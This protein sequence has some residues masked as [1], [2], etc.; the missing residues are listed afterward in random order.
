MIEP[1]ILTEEIIRLGE[2]WSRECLLRIGTLGGGTDIMIGLAEVESPVD[3]A[4]LKVRLYLTTKGLSAAGITFLPK[5]KYRCDDKGYFEDNYVIILD[6]SRE[7]FSGDNKE[8]LM[9]ATLLHELTHVVDPDFVADCQKKK[10]DIKKYE[11]HLAQYT[12]SSEQRAFTSMWI[13]ELKAVL[14]GNAVS[15]MP[16]LIFA[17]QISAKCEQ[18]KVFYEKSGLLDQTLCHFERMTTALQPRLN[19]Q[20]DAALERKRRIDELKAKI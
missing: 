16:A 1:I 17:A 12:L 6:A 14:E 15:T 3:K 20:T 2:S 8:L 4:K 13:A 5:E 19:L 11:G 9:L 10:A 7:E 18:F